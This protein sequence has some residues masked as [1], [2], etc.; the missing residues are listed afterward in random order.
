MSH[1]LRIMLN[2]G[3]QPYPWQIDVLEGCHE[4]LLLNCCRQA[5]KST[6]VAILALT[7]AIFGRDS[8]ILLLSRSYR[9]SRE[10]FHTILRFYDRL[11]TPMKRSRSADGLEL[12]N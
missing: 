3:F 1:A 4:R 5:G 10:L 7:E 8:Q 12:T 2:L 6:V 11:E 9:Q